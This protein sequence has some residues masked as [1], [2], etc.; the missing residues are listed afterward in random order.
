MKISLL[1]A[2]IA[3]TTVTIAENKVMAS[4]NDVI[5]HRVSIPLSTV[6]SVSILTEK[7]DLVDVAL[8][9]FNNFEH[10]IKPA[11]G[12]TVNATNVQIITHGIYSV[13]AYADGMGTTILYK[14]GSITTD[15]ERGHGLSVSNGGHIQADNLT[16]HTSGAL[17]R[18]I[19]AESGGLVELSNSSIVTEGGPKGNFTAGA[20]ANGGARV[21][22]NNT[23]VLAKGDSS[24]GLFVVD[25][26]SSVEMTGGSV[27]TTGAYSDAVNA[28][29][30]GTNITLN[31]VN[32][33]TTG[34]RSR[35]IIAGGTGDTNST[36]Y[37]SGG[38]IET[39]GNG[40]TGLLAGGG[41]QINAADIRV[42]TQ[43]ESATGVYATEGGKITLR[44]SDI[45]TS[46]TK[47]IAIDA[48]NGSVTVSNST[49]G[50]AQGDALKMI[51]SS[52]LL[53]NGTH[54][55]SGNGILLSV[56]DDLASG[57]ASSLTLDNEV[58]A[59]GDI[60]ALLPSS[61][62]TIGVSLS[63]GSHWKGATDAVNKLHLGTD[64]VWAMTDSSVIGALEMDHGTVVFDKSALGAFKTLTIDG[65]LNGNGSFAMN[66]DL[67]NLR[68][69]LVKVNGQALGEHTL[70]IEDSGLSPQNAGD[71]LMVVGTSGG[72]GTFDLYGGHVDAGA[73]RYTLGREGND[74]YL[75][76]TALKPVDPIDPITPV[77]PGPENLSKGANAAIAAHTASATM[78]NA[79]M[80]ALVKRLGEL[81]MGK[82]EGGIWTRAIGKSFNVGEHSSRA[83]SQ[84]VTGI[85]IGAD[86]AIHLDSGKVYV[87]GMVGTAKSDLNF[88]EGASG[89]IESK[90][91]GA[92]ATYINENG[93]YIDGVIKYN[94]FDNTLKTPT[95]LGKS[96]KGSYST[97][98]FGADVEI[99]KHVKLGN[100]WFVEPQLEITATRTQGASYTASNGL[101]V[102]SG[103]IDSLQSR[104][105]SLFG[106]SL[107]LENGMNVQPYVKASYVSEHAG[108]SKVSV[109]GTKLSAELPGNRVELGFGGII[110]VSE[111]SKISLDAEYAKGNSIEQP[112][113]VNL[114]YR[115]MW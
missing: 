32:V 14:D 65:D 84:N 99:G 55:S 64:S 18:G 22:L 8:E 103:D 96:V 105:G 68:G 115:Y 79:Q 110:Q 71:K 39:S 38:S 57:P 54:V 4:T 108:S 61:E 70:V 60:R 11:L 44:D 2:S 98:G 66:T 52:I 19:Q 112:W 69:D 50:S 75:V 53:N 34:Q 6:P 24:L 45:S 36:V 26:G 86:K 72:T 59:I 7:T 67:S 25:K 3:L 28:H 97:N 104:V 31:N 9:T 102:K 107:E 58:T 62:K 27:T 12:E 78:W 41:G 109:N 73:F 88:G 43:G 13:G 33:T 42:K 111:K 20:T 80:N 51:N 16:I 92:Y 21:V 29:L 101:S 5:D 95:N 77:T 40:A 49:V 48:Y 56:R 76:N 89:D 10:A 83:Y 85:E 17:G 113:G 37:M 90:M 100:G 35:G 47:A 106:R 30:G 91:V 1:A 87:G 74:W 15:G 82:D 93:I 114:G 23:T 63:R 94:R 46:G 81:R